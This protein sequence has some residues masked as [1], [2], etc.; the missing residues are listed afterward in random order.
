MLGKRKYSQ[1]RRG[2]ALWG[3]LA[4]VALPAYV[5]AQNPARP[6]PAAALRGAWQ[7]TGTLLESC[8]C[9][10]PCSCNFGEGPS[11]HP[12]CHAVYG[13]RLEKATYDGVDLSGLVVA[14]ADGPKGSLGFLDD[15]AT[16]AQRPALAKLAP[17]LF[18]QG[19]A[20]D[21]PRPLVWAAIMHSIQG[22]NLRLAVAGHG[23][24]A[25]R[26]LIGRDGKTPIV[27]ENNSVWPIARAVKGKAAPLDYKDASV[28]SIHGD[29]T[30]ANYG[31]FTFAGRIASQSAR[32]GMLTLTAKRPCCK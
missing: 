8:T 28:G 32:A 19:G 11:P 3:L 12:Y 25:A 9:A 31:T 30:N 4:A 7:A 21:G 23:G 5:A 1:A 24:F 16:A 2:L 17:L 18:A 27:V 13:Y 15:R 14:G 6:A 22:N 26:V 20:A 29:G 10:V